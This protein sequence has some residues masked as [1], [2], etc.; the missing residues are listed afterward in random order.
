MVAAKP[1][2]V[3]LEAHA[4]KEQRATTDSY[5]QENALTTKQRPAAASP[6][7]RSSVV[8]QRQP[9]NPFSVFP[10]SASPTAH[11]SST[12]GQ[13]TRKA[14][15]S[16][17]ALHANPP[18]PVRWYTPSCNSARAMCNCHRKLKC[19]TCEKWRRRRDASPRMPVDEGCHAN[20]SNPVRPPHTAL[21]NSA[22]SMCNC[23]PEKLNCVRWRYVGLRQA[24]G[25]L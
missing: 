4:A 18:A 10:P 13:M 25:C 19:V 6:L 2:K 17:K 7:H 21:Q 15:T 5:E 3:G 12:A 24:H 14:P 23:P 20:P 8:P 9:I 11:P 16:S 22:R 1:C